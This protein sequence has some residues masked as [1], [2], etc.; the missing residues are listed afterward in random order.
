I[1]GRRHRRDR[2]CSMFWEIPDDPRGALRW[3]LSKLRSLVDES[4]RKRILA[5]RETVGFDTEGVEIDVLNVRKRL[6]TGSDATTRGQFAEAAALFRGEFLEGLDLASCPEF[7]AWCLA[8]RQDLKTLHAR[9]LRSLAAQFAT[10]PE[11]ALPHVRSLV[12]LDP[13]DEAARA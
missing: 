5:D 7:Q 12:T 9:L 3:S 1:N 8:E 10:Q 4:G 11:Q 6:R 2:L 13:F